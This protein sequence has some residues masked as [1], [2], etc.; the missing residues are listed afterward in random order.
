MNL[1]CVLL[2]SKFAFRFNLNRYIAVNAAVERA[3]ALSDFTRVVGRC[4][5]NSVYP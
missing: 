4:K 1:K 2:V 3:T 5:L